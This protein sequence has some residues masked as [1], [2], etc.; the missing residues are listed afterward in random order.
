[1]PMYNVLI[2]SETCKEP[3]ICFVRQESKS[4]RKQNSLSKLSKKPMLWLFC[5][6]E[7]WLYDFYT[8]NAM[9]KCIMN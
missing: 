7:S 9:S 1:M 8:V 5:N 2:L 6:R 4:Y 3:H